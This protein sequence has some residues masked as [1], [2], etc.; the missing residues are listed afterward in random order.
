[1]GGRADKLVAGGRVDSV[2]ADRVNG[3]ALSWLCPQV[4]L[5]WG[6]VAN[7]LNCGGTSARTGSF[8]PDAGHRFE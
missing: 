2:H 7:F 6:R 4:V 8:A 1:M 3:R 5:D